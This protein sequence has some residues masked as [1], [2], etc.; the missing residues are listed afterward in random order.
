VLA[1]HPQVHVVNEGANTL[2]IARNVIDMRVPRKRLDVGT[3]DVMGIGMGCA[4]ATAVVSGDPVV[5]PKAI[6]RSALAAWSSK[7][8]AAITMVFL[9]SDGGFQ[10]QKRR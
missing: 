4:I 6:A 7:P 8:F 10:I 1:D 9:I 3:W 5:P 2:D